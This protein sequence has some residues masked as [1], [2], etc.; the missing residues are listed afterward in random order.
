MHS[1]AS[2]KHLNYVNIVSQLEIVRYEISIHFCFILDFF[3]KSI[4]KSEPKY[5]EDCPTT[6]TGGL[7]NVMRLQL[8]RKFLVQLVIDNQ[9]YQKSLG[10]ADE[11]N[12]GKISSNPI[13]IRSEANFV[14]DFF[15]STKS[16]TLL[17]RNQYHQNDKPS[18]LGTLA[19]VASYR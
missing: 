10:D 9:L 8:H 7:A 6:N 15:Y 3:C 13:P 11:S 14:K 17:H 16:E 1:N 5:K 12:F 4:K 18:K 2:Y 19:S